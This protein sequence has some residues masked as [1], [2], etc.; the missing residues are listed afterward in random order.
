MIVQTEGIVLKSFDFR[1]TSRIAT[2]YTKDHGKVKGVLKGIRKDPRKFGSSV[3]KFTINDIV[4]Y[5]YSRSD[6]HLISQCDLKQYYLPIRQDYKRTVA[7]Q[8]ALELID[9]IMQTEEVNR[10]IYKLILD[11]LESLQEIVDIDKLVHVFQ[12][13]ILKLSGFSPHL[14]SCVVCNKKVTGRTRFSLIEGGLICPKCPSR[15]NTFTL[16]SQGTIASILHVED[17]S[18]EHSLRLGLTSR[19]KQELKYVLNNFLVYHLEK[20]VKSSKY[21]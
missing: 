5:R 8:Y 16:V 1:E 17:C 4:Y 7:A 19:V 2:V 14:D 6:I 15:E 18:W 10:A 20:R 12:I 13:K 11:Y 3:D 21:L 9:I